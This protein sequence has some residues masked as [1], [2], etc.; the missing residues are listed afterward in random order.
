MHFKVIAYKIAIPQSKAEKEKVATLKAKEKYEIWENLQQIDLPNT[1]AID[2]INTFCANNFFKELNESTK[3]PQNYMPVKLEFPEDP[4]NAEYYTEKLKHEINAFQMETLIK[5]HAG[6]ALAIRFKINEQK[7]IHKNIQDFDKIIRD[8]KQ[9]EKLIEDDKANQKKYTILYGENKFTSKFLPKYTNKKV[10]VTTAVKLKKNLEIKK[11]EL[12]NLW[13]SPY[14]V[15]SNDKQS[16]KVGLHPKSKVFLWD[17]YQDQ[18]KEFGVKLENCPQGTTKIKPVIEPVV[19][20]SKA[21]NFQFIEKENSP[22]RNN[23]L[24]SKEYT[25]L[26]KPVALENFQGFLTNLSTSEKEKFKSIFNE[27]LLKISPVKKQPIEDS[28]ESINNETN[29]LGKSL[30]LKKSEKTTSNISQFNS[31]PDLL[32]KKEKLDTEKN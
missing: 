16:V 22:E 25:D 7:L 21:K 2:Q 13:N 30:A 3:L 11:Q 8:I 4:A 14:R 23:Y 19:A 31:S 12:I 9:I 10:T 32:N 17:K 18:L 5:Q 1:E 24:K 28:L 29:V 26:Y 20:N 27:A 15:L 6:K